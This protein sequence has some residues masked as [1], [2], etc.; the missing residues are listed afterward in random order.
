MKKVTRKSLIIRESGRSTDFITPSFGYGCKLDCSYC[1]MKRHTDDNSL[2]IASNNGD[3]LT[4]VNDHAMWLP[5]KEPNQTDSKYWT[6]DLSCNEDFALHRK[7]HN[8]RYIFDFFKNHNKIKGSFATKVIPNDFLEYCPS[9]KIRIRFS[10]L[11]QGISTL[12]R[13]TYS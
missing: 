10:L 11:P 7:Y 6:Y 9:E 8:W 13:T 4:A 5:I 2:S 3:I 1:Y 12:S